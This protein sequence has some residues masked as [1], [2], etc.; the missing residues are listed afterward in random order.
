MQNSKLR[1]KKKNRRKKSEILKLCELCNR[2]LPRVYRCRNSGKLR[3]ISCANKEQ[4]I[5]NPKTRKHRKKAICFFCK[6]I[7]S[8][9]ARTFNNNPVCSSCYHK[10]YAKKDICV[11]CGKHTYTYARRKNLSICKKC[12]NQ[13]FAPKEKCSLCGR[14]RVVIMRNEKNEAICNSCHRQILRK[15]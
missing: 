6:N 12:Y 13:Y 11:G 10:E 4:Q 5:L 15:K 9:Q 1:S 14:I 7:R 8:I 2:K 3:C